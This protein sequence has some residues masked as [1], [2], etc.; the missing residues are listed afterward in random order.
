MTDER[1]VPAAGLESL[2][3]FYDLARRKQGADR[4]DWR[5]GLADE[6]PFKDKSVDCVVTTLVMHHLPRETKKA[7]LAEMALGLRPGGTLQLADWGKAHGPGVRAAFFGLQ[8]LDGFTNTADNVAG[9]LPDYVAD[10]GFTGV[11]RLKRI[12]TV[13]GSFEILRASAPA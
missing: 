6:L 9:L 2:T 4:I 11:D 13:A 3:R 10:A 5:E 8:L 12:R 1:Y 7:A